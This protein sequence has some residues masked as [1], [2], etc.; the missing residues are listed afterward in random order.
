MKNKQKNGELSMII[1]VAMVPDLIS[2]IIMMI[3]LSPKSGKKPK[4]LLKER[5]PQKEQFY[6]LE[7][8]VI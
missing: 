3:T 7:I 5:M 4:Q 6:F 8:I 2:L 1:Q